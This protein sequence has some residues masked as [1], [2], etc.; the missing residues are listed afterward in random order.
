MLSKLATVHLNRRLPGDDHRLPGDDCGLD[1]SMVCCSCTVRLL[2]S[3]CLKNFNVRLVLLAPLD[4]IN[5]ISHKF[6]QCSA[7]ACFLVQASGGDLD[8]GRAQTAWGLR[9]L[10]RLYVGKVQGRDECWVEASGIRE[11][12]CD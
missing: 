11:S 8:D 7:W 10:G 4:Q 5:F 1:H 12:A 6:A 3:V 9:A 2:K